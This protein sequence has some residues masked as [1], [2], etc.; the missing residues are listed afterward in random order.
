MK[1]ES[2]GNCEQCSEKRIGK[3]E[4]GKSFKS[5]VQHSRLGKVSSGE[6]RCRVDTLVLV[7]QK[8]GM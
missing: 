3:S 7:S 4:G 1:S 8:A 6:E 2:T 5:T